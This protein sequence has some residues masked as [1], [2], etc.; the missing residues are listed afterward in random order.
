MIPMLIDGPALEPV[1]LAEAKSWLKVEGSDE[2]DL[3]RGL[4]VAA[5]LMVEAEI[6]QVLIAQNWRLV[7]DAWPPGE[8]ISVRVGRIIAAPAARVFDAVSQP[9]ALPF[10]SI[11]IRRGTRP[12]AVI[13]T[14]RPA[15][16]RARAGIE[17]DIRLGF[18]EAAADVPETIRL[19]IRRLV[20]LWYE[21]RGD[22]EAEVGLPAQIRALLKPF[23]IL[24]LS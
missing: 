22:G 16:G 5:R 24:R 10:D 2:D 8:E 15:P 14:P 23:R 13:I 11:R 9:A 1:S 12:H 17:I 18:G 20:A 7:G 21:D 19:A 4:I 3:I 6:G